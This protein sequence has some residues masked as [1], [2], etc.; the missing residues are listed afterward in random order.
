MARSDEVPTDPIVGGEMEADARRAPVV[1][2]DD[3]GGE[4]TR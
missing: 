4:K 2:V 3:I 1:R